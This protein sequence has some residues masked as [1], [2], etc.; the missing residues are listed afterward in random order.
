MS[1]FHDTIS[2]FTALT[3]RATVLSVWHLCIQELMESNSH[4]ILIICIWVF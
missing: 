3:L 1:F 2:S 4:I